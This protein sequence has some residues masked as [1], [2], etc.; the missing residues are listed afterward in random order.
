MF[1]AVNRHMI[2]K[3]LEKREGVFTECILGPS[4]GYLRRVIIMRDCEWSD[5]V[6]F[7]VDDDILV[8]QIEVIEKSE[9]NKK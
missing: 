7:P 8:S 2:S 4:K 9:N 3:F 5:F 6:I 1:V